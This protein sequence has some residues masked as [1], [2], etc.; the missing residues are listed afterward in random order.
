MANHAGS[1]D[2]S[3]P[4]R[5]E[6][7]YNV[8]LAS[9][10]VVRCKQ[11]P[12]VVKTQAVRIQSGSKNRARSIGRKFINATA[13]SISSAQVC[14]KYVSCGITS[15]TNGVGQPRTK[16]DPCAARCEFGQTVAPE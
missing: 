12:L 1:E 8:L 2:A 15:D 5:R 11:V 7:I 4:I 9:A 13:V 6:F 3:R 16:T 10:G 14:H